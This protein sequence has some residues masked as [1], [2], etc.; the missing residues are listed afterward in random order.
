MGAKTKKMQSRV[1]QMERRIHR[2]IREKEGL[3]ADLERPADL[4][5]MPLR[6]HKETLVHIREYAARYEDAEEPLFEGLTFHVGRGQRIALHGSNGCGKSTLLKMIL[7]KAGVIR[8]PLPIRESGV[9]ETAS[10]L[11]ISCVSQDT[12]MLQGSISQFC[13][14]RELEESLFCAILRQLDMDRIQ[15]LK[16]MEEYS[17]GQKKKVLIA[18]SLLTPAHLYVWDEPLNYVDVFSRM[19]IEKL[20]MEY[21]PTMLFVEHDVRFREKIATGTVEL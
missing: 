21:E 15:F 1:K 6:H 20:I 8:E 2:E 4:K 9:C 11:V 7:W 12:S 16:G 5:I 14:E 18:A 10:G 19:Q 13:K 3:L 17:E